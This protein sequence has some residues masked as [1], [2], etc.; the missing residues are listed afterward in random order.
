ML[1][2][3]YLKN[4]IIFE[5]E[6]IKFAKGLNVITGETGSG[7]SIIIDAI[8]ILCGGRF[9]K[10]DI[11][12]GANK[13]FIE[14]VFEIKEYNNELDKILD[15]YGISRESDNILLIQREVNLNGRSLC[16]INGQTVTLS[17]LKNITQNII[18]IV[19]QNEH[20][21]LFKHSSH[22]NLIDNFGTAELL[23]LKKELNYLTNEIESVNKILDNLYG[24]SQERERKLD[25]LKY[26]IDEIE[27]ANIKI[28][29]LDKLKNRKAILNNAEKLY[30]VISNIYEILYSGRNLNKS[31]IDDLGK[32]LSDINSISNIDSS[33]NEYSNSIANC[34]YQLEDL[35]SPLRSYKDNIE[36]NSSE[37]DIIEERLSLI[38]KLSKKY[39]NTI[40]KIF[41]Y[42]ENA[43]NEYERLKNSEETILKLDEKLKRLEEKYF[44]K[45]KKLSE[46]RNNISKS[47]EAKIESELNDLNMEGAKFFVKNEI[48][49]NFINRNGIDRIEFMLSANPG[50]VEKPLV[51]VA[52]GGEVSRIMLA[53]KTVLINVENVNCIIFDEIDAGIGGITANMVAEKLKWI[54]NTKQTLCITHLAQIASLGDNHLHVN[55]YI[56]GDKTYATIKKITKDE[57]IIEVAK[58][59]DGGKDSKLSINLAKELL[60]KK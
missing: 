27:K 46:I 40:E 60:N 58:M 9:V 41:E 39:G 26:Q 1:H 32:C 51:K 30:N 8:E 37:I 31:V 16:R 57:R 6:R 13:A 55:K 49:E 23:E 43:K 53:L 45:A 34:L 47:V 20:Q 18:D 7:K 38:D 33:I 19:A 50:E 54:S 17:M 15:D 56:E 48:R 10:E 28:D 3:L 4:Y 14:G 11:K 5:N 12:T 36:F 29:E 35:K 22:I 59:L 21:Q 44:I 52:S 25:L 2:E 24:T 42:M